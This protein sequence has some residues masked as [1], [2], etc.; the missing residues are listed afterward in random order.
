MKQRFSYCGGW[1][2][3]KPTFEVLLFHNFIKI[4][5]K[6]KI[7]FFGTGYVGLVTGTCFA[8]LGNDVIC[9]DV[10]SKK[11]KELNDGNIPFMNQ[12]LRNQLKEMQK[13]GD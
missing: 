5:I 13:K 2:L 8:D 11:I 7:S 9:V 10:N 6:M 12:D 1:K 4:F 3:V